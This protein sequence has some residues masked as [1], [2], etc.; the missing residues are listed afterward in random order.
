MIGSVCVSVHSKE[1]V[2]LTIKMFM[3]DLFSSYVLLF[4]FFKEII[5][6]GECRRKS[7]ISHLSQKKKSDKIS[8]FRKWWGHVSRVLSES[9]TYGS[10]IG[11]EALDWTAQNPDLN[12]I[13]HLWDEQCEP[14]IINQ[15]TRCF[16]NVFNC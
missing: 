6:D 9:D 16:K 1:P 8:H 10:W 2:D 14:T 12:L 4:I 11:V 13:Q 15:T 3:K 5:S 7:V